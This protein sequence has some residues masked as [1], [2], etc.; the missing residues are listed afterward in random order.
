MRWIGYPLAAVGAVVVIGLV[1][2]LALGGG[3]GQ[4]RLVRTIEINKPADVVF[5]W[6]TEPPRLKAWVGWLRDV[7]RPAPDPLGIGSREVWVMEDRNN[8]NQLMEIHAEYTQVEPGRRLEARLNAPA[9]FTGTVT[10]ELQPIDAR[11]TL[12][13]Y[14]CEYRFE[15]WLAKLFEPLISRSAQQKLN[16]DLERMKQ[17]AEAE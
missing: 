9:A 12:L 17:K 15:H 6:I 16:E 13:T 5:E 8:N 10:Y 3:R 11:R 4:S 1:I 14:R 7:Q 2:L